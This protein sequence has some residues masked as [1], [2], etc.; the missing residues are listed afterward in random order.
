VIGT[1]HNE[2]FAIAFADPELQPLVEEA[3]LK[4]AQPGDFPGSE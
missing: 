3:R 1:E 2:D 4:M